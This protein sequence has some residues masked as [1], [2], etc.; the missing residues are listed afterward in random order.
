MD[1]QSKLDAQETLKVGYCNPPTHSR[2][3]KG[4]S[5]NPQGRPKGTH[6]IGKV[7]E[8]TL[9]EKVIIKWECVT[10]KCSSARSMV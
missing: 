7:L 2:F 6:N 10:G 4:H 3:K 1:G 5:G 9:R 8:R